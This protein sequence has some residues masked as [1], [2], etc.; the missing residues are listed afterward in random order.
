MLNSLCYEC[1]YLKFEVHHK[2]RKK[3]YCESYPDGLPEQAFFKNDEK[4]PIPPCIYENRTI[5]LKQGDYSI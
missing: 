5:Q 4:E 2:N 1:E 3:Y